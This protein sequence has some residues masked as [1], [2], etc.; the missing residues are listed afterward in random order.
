LVCGLIAVSAAPL[1][2]T[3]ISSKVTSSKA[4]D[5]ALNLIVTQTEISLEYYITSCVDV[6]GPRLIATV[7]SDLV[8]EH[9]CERISGFF[10]QSDR[11]SPRAPM[12]FR[13]LLP[14]CSEGFGRSVPN[15]DRSKVKVLAAR[16]IR[17]LTNHGRAMTPQSQNALCL[18]LYDD[19]QG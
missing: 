18:K 11:S 9:D 5:A 2:L 16:Q 19:G 17:C 3:V 4:L 1:N 12:G 15:R 6:Y 7:C 13:A 14:H 10:E 8:L